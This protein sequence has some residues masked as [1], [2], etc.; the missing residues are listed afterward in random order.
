[1][2]RISYEKHVHRDPDFPFFFHLDAA[3]FKKSDRTSYHWHESMEI[4]SCVSGSFFAVVNGKKLRLTPGE[5]VV[6]DPMAMHT[7][8]SDGS[9]SRY[10]CLIVDKSFC[11]KNCLALPSGRDA[12]VFRDARSVE[13]FGMIDSEIREKREGWKQAVSALVMMLCVRL[14]RIFGAGEEA[15]PS[16]MRGPGSAVA[17][18]VTEY[19]YDNMEKRFSM[20]G[21]CAALGFNRYY[22]CHCFREATGDSIV[23]FLNR[24]RCEQA[25]KLIA[26]GNHTVGEAAEMSGFSSFSYFSKIYKKNFGHQPSADKPTVTA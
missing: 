26:S 14:S 15:N 6:V 2:A 11:E 25:R 20:D 18:S 9:D 21:L 13:I 24:L 4:L 5:T 12:G 17:Q 10:Y 22:L 7:T 16:A 23:S 1:M 3:I 19:L 8:V